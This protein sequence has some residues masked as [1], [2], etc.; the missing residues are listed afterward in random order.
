M[1]SYYAYL[2]CEDRSRA[3][4]KTCR[5][6]QPAGS[7]IAITDSRAGRAA[8]ALAGNSTVRRNHRFGM[9]ELLGNNPLSQNLRIELPHG[10]VE[11]SSKTDPQQIGY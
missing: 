8:S 3:V 11:C 5:P 7:R 9:N 1:N 6:V 4:V 10:K 2:H